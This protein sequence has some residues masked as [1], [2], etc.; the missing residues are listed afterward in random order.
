VTQECEHLDFETTVR[1]NRFEDT[2]RFSAE[3]S[4]KCC[5]CG[6]PFRFLGV[7]SVGVSWSGPAVDLRETMLHVPIEPEGTPSVRSHASFEMP[8]ELT[9]QRKH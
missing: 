8:P 4:I 6:E 7:D 1:V 5:D 2:G 3:V 9:V